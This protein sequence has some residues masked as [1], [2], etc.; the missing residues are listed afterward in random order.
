[1][2]KENGFTV[3]E[4]IKALQERNVPKNYKVRFTTAFHNTA[5]RDWYIDD[6]DKE[7]VLC[8]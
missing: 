3:E 5:V 8:D 2:F 4:L 1:M 6:Q 7:I